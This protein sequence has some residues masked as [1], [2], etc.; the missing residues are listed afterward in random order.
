MAKEAE[1]AKKKTEEENKKKAEEI[2]E[3]NKNINK[4]LS[5]KAKHGK[6]D[7]KKDPT[8]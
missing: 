7:S 1:D 6:I 8:K 5:A 3:K 2:K 4:K